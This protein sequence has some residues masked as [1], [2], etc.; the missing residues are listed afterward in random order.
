M[1]GRVRFI[2]QRDTAAL[3]RLLPQIQALADSEREALGFLPAAAIEEAIGRQRLF[4]ATTEIG[5]SVELAGY[6]LHGGVFPHAKVQQIAAVPKFRKSGVASTLMKSFVSELERVGFMTIKAEVASDLPSALAFYAASGFEFV[7]QRAGGQTRNRTILIHVRQLETDSLFSIGQNKS[8]AVFDL[9]IRRRSAGDMPFFAF[10]LNVYFDLVKDRNQSDYARRLFGA[11]LGHDI[12]LAVADEFVIELRRTS[13]GV[14]A[15]PVLQLALQLP[16]LP[17]IDRT[18]LAKMAERIHDLVFVQ[19]QVKGAGSKQ[20]LS[21]ARHL[22]HAA[23][24]RASAFVTRDGSILAARNELLSTIGIDVAALGELIALLPSELPSEGSTTI[25]GEGFAI[26]AISSHELSRYMADAKISATLISEFV[27]DDAN[28]S[29]VRREAIS[30]GGR[31][32]A[33]GVLKI[34]KGIE[35]IARLL[36]HVSPEHAD[37]EMFADFL[38]DSL[39]KSACRDSAISMELIHL[40]GQSSIGSIATARGFF[41]AGNSTNYSKIAIGRP[42]TFNNWSNVTQAIRRRTGLVLPDPAP[43]GCDGQHEV[44]ITTPTGQSVRLGVGRLEDMLSPTI[45]IWP[46]RD[47]VIVPISR[48]Y[49][50]DL[51]GTSRQSNFAFIANRD[52]AFL[53]RRAYVNSPR[54]AKQMRPD[55]PVLFYESKRKGGGRGAVVAVARIVDSVV[56]RKSDVPKDGHRRLVVDSV[57]SFSASDDVLLTT[58]DNLFVLPQPVPFKK[59]KEIDAI[60]RAN[61]ISAVSLSSEKITSVLTQ[62]WSGGKL[63]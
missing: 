60:G 43:Q 61:L 48:A 31:I 15:D 42:L 52:A 16:R 18:E 25:Q 59:L 62:G 10:D 53:S 44:E 7:R 20:A 6:L 50:D 55:S 5:G 4:A 24:S 47:G 45:F 41:R 30:E 57:D 33:V 8:S 40:P 39:V 11:A 26:D 58:F 51:L 56:L 1:K 13:N 35:P 28:V 2:I 49:A 63:Q 9:G 17:K 12:R 23:L 36:V 37:C 34:P 21:D 19:K 14:A 22:A 27:A 29:P 54:A 38:L 32:V 3:A 46:G